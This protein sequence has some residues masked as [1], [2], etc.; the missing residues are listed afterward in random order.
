MKIPVDRIRIPEKRLSAQFDEETAALFKTTVEKLGVIQDPVVRALP[1]GSYELIAGAH[2]LKELVA[3]GQTEVEVKVVQADGK[4]SRMMN[5]MENLARGSYN[6]IAL[7]E[8]FKTYLDEGG[9]TDEVSAIWNKTPETVKFYL[10]LLELPERYIQA[11]KEGK[12]LVTHIR[13]AL[14]LPD[15][16]EIDAALKTALD[17]RWNAAVLTH[18]V[19]NR[20]EQYEAAERALRETGVETPPPPPNP[21]ELVRYTTCLICGKMKATS[22]IHLPT[23]C[24]DCYTFA[25]YAVSQ[26]GSG[27]EG[28]DYLYRALTNY[29]AYI[30]IQR[31]RAEEDRIATITG[32]PPTPPPGQSGQA[33]Q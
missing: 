21:A 18:Y 3:R 23:T 24:A 17:L 31:R 30:E 13:E 4:T 33:P 27:K 25:K 11:L 9:T 22:E 29:Q 26:I 16:N 1:D 15:I 12:L 2:R 7:A 19:Q 32:K 14:R 6:P 28:M 5:I 10:S 8:A 20:L